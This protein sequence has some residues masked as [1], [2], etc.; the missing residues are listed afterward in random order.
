MA[1]Y[2]MID[3]LSVTDPDTF[4]A[5]HTLAPSAV[6]SHEGTYVLPPGTHIEALEGNWTPNRIVLIEFGDADRAKQWW[7]SPE[8]AEARAIHREATISNIILVESTACLRR[9]GEQP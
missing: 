3:R 5:Y 4:D 7:D 9:Q 6:K 8:Y 2:I 1:A